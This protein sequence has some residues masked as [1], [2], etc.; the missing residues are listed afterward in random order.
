MTLPQADSNYQNSRFT[1]LL[2]NGTKVTGNLESLSYIPVSNV[3]AASFDGLSL[4]KEQIVAAFGSGLSTV[5]QTA[6]TVPLPTSLGGTSVRIKDSAGVEQLA[7]IFFAAPTQVNYLIPRGVALGTATVA[8]TAANGITSTGLTQISI[9]APSLFAA[10]SNGQGVAAAVALRVKATGVQSYEV[11]ARFD[12]TQNKYIS[13][14]LDLSSATDK[15]FLILFGTGI[16][17]RTSLLGVSAKIGGL[18]AEV[19]FA[20]A[21]GSLVGV[22]QVNVRIP[23]NLG[24]RGEVNL[25]LSVDAKPSNIVKVNIK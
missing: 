21:Q 25:E 19:T 7:P 8:V 1:A 11:I 18:N 13:V 24:G 5:T 9:V 23:P 16:R 14:P 6:Q 17:Y 2:S 3:S 4:A 20:Q 15:V 10:N 12:Q 22:D